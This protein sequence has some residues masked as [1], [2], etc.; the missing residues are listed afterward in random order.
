METK[1]IEFNIDPIK[2]KNFIEKDVGGTE[3]AT[4]LKKFIQGCVTLGKY[5]TIICFIIAVLIDI[6]IFLNGKAY[7]FFEY[8]AP[9]FLIVIPGAIYIVGIIARNQSILAEELAKS[10]YRDVIN[11]K[12]YI[13]G[14]TLARDYINKNNEEIFE[15][16]YIF[17][18]S[19]LKQSED[20]LYFYFTFWTE[21]REENWTVIFP[22][23][24]EE[25]VFDEI[26]SI[27]KNNMDKVIKEK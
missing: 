6:Y 12:I 15:R 23:Y 13:N 22:D 4:K 17:S 18:M 16:Y 25:S 10:S 9:F 1:K 3:S 20:K 27:Q 24:C 11:E 14:Y 26:V 5:L 8:F 19:N 2:K 21:D 7:Y